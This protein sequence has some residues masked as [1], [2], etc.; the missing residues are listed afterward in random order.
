MVSKILAFLIIISAAVTAQNIEEVFASANRMYQQK[1]YDKSVQLY[2]ELVNEGYEGVSLYY[3]LGNAYY[4]LDN[5]G[6]AILY[7]EKALKLAPVDEDIRH[8]LRLANAKTTDKLTE[9][10][11]FFLFN[12]WENIIDFFSLKGWIYTVY[13][14][15]IMLLL[16]LGGYLLLRNPLYQKYS[17][18]SGIILLIFFIFSTVIM[19]VKLNRDVNI[20]KGILV[21]RQSN[22]KASPDQSSNDAFIIHEGLKVTIE[23]RVGE[24]VKVKLNDGKTGWIPEEHIRII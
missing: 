3:N 10:P 6:Y 21:E 23:D 8:N 4:R 16:S 14:L 19:S 11:P 22:V 15:F 5:L 18:F 12:I 1:Q 9:F 20:T 7:Y 2:E 24:W 13:I 17:F